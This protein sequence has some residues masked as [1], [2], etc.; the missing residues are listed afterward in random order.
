MNEIDL[1]E[2]MRAELPPARP[3]SRA[4][5]RGLLI[6]R[7]EAA[8]PIAQPRPQ[9]MRR[10]WLSLAVAGTA[11]AAAL[12]VLAIGLGDGGGQVQPAVAQVLRQTAEVAAA[13]EPLTL[14][15]GQFLY[16]RSTNAYLHSTAG[17]SVLVP[18]RTETWASMDGRRKGRTRQVYGQP[19]FVSAGQRAAWVAAGSPPLSKAGAVE[20]SVVSGGGMVDAAL[21]PTDPATL[22]EM[23]EAREI[24]GVEGPPGE[25]ETFRLVGDL[26]RQAYLPP[27][28]RAALYQLTAELPGVELLG[29]VRDP[30]GR[31]GTGV[32]YV[33]DQD[34]IRRELIFDPATSALL[35]ERESIVRS[36]AYGVDA[37]PGTPVSYAA[38]LESKVVDSVGEGA[39]G[40]AGSRENSVGCYEQ[41]SLHGTTAIIHGND[42]IAT[43]AEVWREGALDSP[44]GTVPPLVA[45]GDGRSTIAH[46]FPGSDPALCGRL[47]LVP[48]GEVT[49]GP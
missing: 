3:E 11:L 39:P 30:V 35:G 49:S 31:P 43:C 7:I 8:A 44:D 32:A 47:G 25:A 2:R 40:G 6:A 37:P 26:L 14:A 10:R 20:D 12:V 46:V 1:L 33:D 24:P 29:E 38:Y 17:W 45:C 36:G 21:L 48:F 16:T 28:V 27:D 18:S 19:R 23:I 42:P 41:P 22:R 4:A 34:G 5:A 9:R 15:P 13:R